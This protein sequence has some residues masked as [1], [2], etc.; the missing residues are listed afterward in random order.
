[1]EM[2]QTTS[3]AA[4]A[5]GLLDS[6]IDV[7][8]MPPKLRHPSSINQLIQMERGAVRPEPPFYA[9]SNA[10]TICCFFEKDVFTKFIRDKK[11]RA[12]LRSGID[13]AAG[14]NLDSEVKRCFVCLSG[15]LCVYRCIC[16]SVFLSFM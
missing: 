11:L 1:M 4:F 16:V 2:I 10:I 7:T 13:W 12:S 14:A 8:V 3:K 6:I 9:I 5:W 15:W